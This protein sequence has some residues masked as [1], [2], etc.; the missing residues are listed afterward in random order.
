MKI[1]AVSLSWAGDQFLGRSYDEM[2]CQRFIEKCL[3][4]LGLHMDL[5][6]SNAWWREMTWTGAPEEC[7]KIF[8]SVPKGAFLF[9]WAMDGGEVK[10]GYT[11][12]RGNASHIGMKTGRGPGAIH[13][14]S[15]R[16]CVAVSEFHDR[17]IP[18]GGWNRVGLWDRIDYGKTINW[19]LEHIGIGDAP[20]QNTQEEGKA[21]TVTVTSPNGKDVNLRKEASKSAALVDRIPDGTKA[22]LLSSGDEWS[23]IQ[24]LG[25][26]GWMMTEF[27]VADDADLPAEDQDDFEPVD[28]GYDQDGA[29]S[30]TLTFTDAELRAA[31]PVLT[32]MAHQII[33]TIG[34]G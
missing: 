7:V 8:G 10:R 18:N 20:A 6:G 12:G 17:T 16:G 33:D 23:K 31:L 34:R 13:S 9:I 2:D 32:K 4:S 21:V 30:I 3:E 22:E 19:L 28:A 15:T 5:K 27:L 26:T 24:A 11:D 14:S 1:D 29:E 25:K